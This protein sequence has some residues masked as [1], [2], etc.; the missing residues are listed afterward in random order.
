MLVVAFQ[1][2]ESVS[3]G[4][5]VSFFLREY[6]EKLS[7]KTNLQFTMRNADE[8][9]R[10]RHRLLCDNAILK[11]ERNHFISDVNSLLL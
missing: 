9:L 10:K 7:I 11:L 3:G 5:A 2:F 1:D 4:T 6:L 8:I